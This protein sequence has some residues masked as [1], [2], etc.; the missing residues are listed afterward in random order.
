[1][2]FLIKTQVK[3]VSGISS[4]YVRL[5]SS[6]IKHDFV[7]NTTEIPIKIG[8]PSGHTHSHLLKTSEV[9]VGITKD[10]LQQR[11]RKLLES[12]ARSS[13]KAE[14]NPKNHIVVIPSA[15]KKYI[16]DKIPYVFRQNS[17][18]RYLSG[19]LEPDSVLI[20]H[21]DSSERHRSILF[22]RP[23]DKHAEMW[24]G[25]RTGPELAL[26]TFGV[27]ESH[28]IKYLPEYLVKFS[29]EYPSSILWADYNALQEQ[30]EVLKAV[31][32]FTH[33]IKKPLEPVTTFIHSLRLIKSPAEV[34]LMRRTCQIACQAITK[35]IQES[36]PGDSEHH[37][38]ARVDYH[39]R[40]GNA[41]FLAYPP[42]IASGNNATTI[43][44]IENNQIAEGG[45]LVLMD[46]GCE[47]GGYTSDI[48]RTWPINGHFTSAQGILYDVILT[49]QKD[50]F[51]TL[52]NAGG[53][54]LDDLFDTMCIKLGLYLQEVGLISKS[55]SGLSLA[56]AAYSFCPHH[57]S[58][59][60]GMDVHDTP[61][62]SRTTILESG[63]VFTVEPGIYIGENR[64]DVPVEFRGLG[65]RIE[66]DCAVTPLNT[67]EILSNQCVKE[68]KELE[69]LVKL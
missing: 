15:G 66:D 47:Y 21:T 57:V 18:F 8:Q 17:D 51:K 19:C 3:I 56:R 20:L 55:L 52:L 69:D 45:K 34:A 48:T 32:S 53:A 63:M 43:H 6:S 67:I 4:S 35:T 60:L 16:S 33:E 68:V 22:L 12:I 9:V 64:R 5:L 28:E 40:M 31:K 39:S 54:C 26:E 29:K 27:D 58:H 61:T 42:V 36:R 62:I 50:L 65:I 30:Q 13:A 10:E 37:I 14:T 25:T 24:D 49:L 46:A 41:D 23:K 44:Y 7:K 59:Y 1:M 2:N 11:R 38:F